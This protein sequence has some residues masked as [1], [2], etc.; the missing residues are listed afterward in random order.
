MYCSNTEFWTFFPSSEEFLF[1]SCLPVKMLS[2]WVDRVLVLLIVPSFQNLLSCCTIFQ[3]ISTLIGSSSMIILVK[4]VV[5]IYILSYSWLQFI[6]LH[7]I[8]QENCYLV[9][10]CDFSCFFFIIPSHVISRCH[11]KGCWSEF[12]E[13]EERMFI[14]YCMI[15][16]SHFKIIILNKKTS[17]LMRKDFFFFCRKRAYSLE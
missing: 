1:Y 4:V 14:V 13:N 15:N 12:N 7:V 9:L 3:L 2:R 17:E 6:Y 10:S 8:S 5:I 16:S 11:T